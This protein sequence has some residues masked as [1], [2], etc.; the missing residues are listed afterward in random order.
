M[1]KCMDSAVEA[2]SI[3][4]RALANPSRQRI[5]LLFAT[6]KELSVSAIANSAELGVST[7]SEHLSELARAGLLI[8]RREGKTVYYRPDVIRI[9]ERLQQLNAYL[10]C[11]CPNLTPANQKD[12]P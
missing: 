7:A 1:T 11:C 8:A 2:L 6:G 5:L 3:F 9:R 4:F 10:D 12:S